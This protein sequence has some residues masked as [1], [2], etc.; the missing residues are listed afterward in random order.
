MIVDEFICSM[1]FILFQDERLRWHACQA[2]EHFLNNYEA[3]DKSQLHSIPSTIQAG[4]LAAM[5][6]L[7][8]NQK[9]KNTKVKNKKYW[10]FIY[11]LIFNVPEPEFSMRKCIRDELEQR[12]L[13]LD[14]GSADG[15]VEVKKI[16]KENKANL[17]KILNHTL[18]I[19]F[20]HF[21]C[22]YFYRT[23]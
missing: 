4:G 18:Q 22:H 9:Q 16:R 15:N 1:D 13:L 12:H 7:T 14:E 10:E 5:R 6:K 20:E 23:G 11:E 19:Y 21:N 3:V 8:D 17:E 2:A